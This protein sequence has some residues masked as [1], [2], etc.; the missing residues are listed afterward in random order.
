MSNDMQQQMDEFF[1]THSYAGVAES[2]WHYFPELGEEV[3]EDDTITLTDE[4]GTVRNLSLVDAD[5]Y[6]TAEDQDADA[7]TKLF[8]T[9]EATASER[10]VI[11]EQLSGLGPGAAALAGAL[12]GL[13]GRV[14]VSNRI[15]EE[16]E[17]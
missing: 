12:R 3:E 5:V 13:V 8:D 10:V 2:A 11:L 7:V 1:E 6:A 14:V 9:G 17:V 4:Q 15:V 16:K